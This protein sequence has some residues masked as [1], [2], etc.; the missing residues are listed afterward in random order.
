M[1]LDRDR[2]RAEVH[3]PLFEGGLWQQTGAGLVDPARLCWGLARVARE[4][5]V[6][7]HEQSPVARLR[8]AGSGVGW[9]GPPAPCGPD[10]PLLATS[11]YRGLVRAIRRRILPVYDYVLVTE[12][13]TPSSAGG[14]AGA[15]ARASAT[16]PTS[17]T[18]TA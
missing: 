17:S 14:S 4:L 13:L 16:S 12:P 5:G 18:T 10:G 1:L 15:T 2:V 3:S 11:A 7:I 6:R 8:A 9:S